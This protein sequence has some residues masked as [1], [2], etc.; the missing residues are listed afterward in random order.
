ME[1]GP[2]A[3]YLL[4]MIGVTGEPPDPAISFDD[5]G[6][7]DPALLSGSIQPMTIR[8][9]ISILVAALPTAELQVL[10]AIL[11]AAVHPDYAIQGDNDQTLQKRMAQGHLMRLSSAI[12]DSYPDAPL[13]YIHLD[14]SQ[15]RIVEDVEVFIRRWKE[16][17]KIPERR[18]RIQDFADYLKV[19]DLR[20][21]WKDGT[22][23]VEAERSFGQVAK[24]LRQSKSTAVNA[25][26][27]AFKRI[28]G[29][30][31]SP[32]LWIRVM[33]LLKLPALNS[34]P[35]IR[36]TARYRRLMSSNAPKPAPESR[37]ERKPAEHGD[38]GLI[39]RES[40][41]DGDQTLVDLAMDASALIQHGFSDIE[42]AQKLELKDPDLIGYLR[43]RLAEV[44]ERN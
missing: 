11:D 15:R 26:R 6:D 41:V 36:L 4:G 22:Y 8:N 21:G 14:A 34:L 5:L 24:E 29:Q 2:A 7:L 1:Y 18:T 28:V 33:G 39:E 30:D 40:T 20:E 13:Y 25:Y 9:M 12:L 27:A 37:V 32:E 38:V 10:R 42:I 3:M 43:R 31:F 16:R 23:Q 35:G 19:W 17:R 44:D